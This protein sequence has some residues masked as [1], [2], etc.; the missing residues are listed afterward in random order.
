VTSRFQRGTLVRTRRDF[1]PAGDDTAR[2]L[3]ESEIGVAV[4][5]AAMG[6]ERSEER[7]GN[8]LF[9][10]AFMKALSEKDVPHHKNGKQYIHHLQTYVFNR[11]T[12]ESEKQHP[13]LHL[14]WTMESFALRKLPDAKP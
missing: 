14:P 11:V 4:M 13:F 3:S 5:C 2:S 9:T 1:K 8:G 10:R 12:E 6:Y 7:E